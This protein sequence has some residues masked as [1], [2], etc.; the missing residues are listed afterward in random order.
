MC[1]CARG[2]RDVEAATRRWFD[3]FSV[4]S[5]LGALLTAD[6]LLTPTPPG[7]PD[8]DPGDEDRS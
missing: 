2:H 4:R 8:H 3:G 6:A 5:N 7:R 1:G